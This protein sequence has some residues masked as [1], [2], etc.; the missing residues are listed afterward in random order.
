M[1]CNKVKRPKACASER[2]E[3]S[4]RTCTGEKHLIRMRTHHDL[5]VSC[6]SS[7][8]RILSK[9][10]WIN[11]EQICTSAG[12]FRDFSK[13][14]LKARTTRQRGIRTTSDSLQIGRHQ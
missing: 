11:F 1:P 4:R 10:A 12:A 3:S 6:R 13:R 5:Y 8:L 2:S 9:H 7:I 14:E